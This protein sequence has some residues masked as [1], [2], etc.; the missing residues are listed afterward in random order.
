MPRSDVSEN[1]QSILVKGGALHHAFT[2]LSRAS[3]HDDQIE[4]L[5]IIRN[6]AFC[7]M[8]T[9]LIFFITHYFLDEAVSMISEEHFDYIILLLNAQDAYP[10]A[11]TNGTAEFQQSSDIQRIALQILYLLSDS[12]T[13]ISFLILTSHADRNRVW[14]STKG[15]IKKLLGF[16]IPLSPQRGFGWTHDIFERVLR[17][18]DRLCLDGIYF[19]YSLTPLESLRESFMEAHGI[20]FVSKVIETPMGFPEDTVLTAGEILA[21]LSATGII[22]F[23]LS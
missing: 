16:F 11:E 13:L 8:W 23:P 7:R 4:L 12:G 19:S 18:F 9:F 20:S 10:T 6:L 17:I 14:L 22:F 15:I 21:N 1:N 2:L 3:A 5:Y